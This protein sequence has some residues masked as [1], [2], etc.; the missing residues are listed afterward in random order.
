[1][2]STVTTSGESRKVARREVLLAAGERRAAL[3]VENG[4]R[5]VPRVE[6]G[7]REGPKVVVSRVAIDCV[8]GRRVGDGLREDRRDQWVVARRVEA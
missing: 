8:E 6:V 4:P 2:V 5:G 3:S 1:M 7:P